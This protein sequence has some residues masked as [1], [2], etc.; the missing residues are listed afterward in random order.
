MKCHPKPAANA[1]RAK[2]LREPRGANALCA[3]A[4]TGRANILDLELDS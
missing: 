1:G 2:D 4:P 3:I